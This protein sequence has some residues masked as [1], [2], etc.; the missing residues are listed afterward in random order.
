MGVVKKT[1]FSE[2]TL[3]QEPLSH[4]QRKQRGHAV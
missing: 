4:V 1:P 2:L 3:T